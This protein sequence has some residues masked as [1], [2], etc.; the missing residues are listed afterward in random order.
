MRYPSRSPDVYRLRILLRDADIA[1]V[2]ALA[3]A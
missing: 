2:G 3:I 1:P